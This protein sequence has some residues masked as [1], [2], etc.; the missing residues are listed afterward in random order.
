MN[1]HAAPVSPLSRGAA[2][3][4]GVAVGGQRHGAAE[5]A[6]TGLPA[7]GELFALLRPGFAPERVNTH[8]A[9]AVSVVDGPPI[10][11]VLPSAES[12]T[13]SRTS[14]LPVSSPPRELFALLGPG[15]ARA[16]E[17]PRGADAVVV[18]GPA[19][20]RGVAVG[21]QRHALAEFAPGRSH[22]RSSSI[23]AG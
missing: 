17:D 12:A 7:A 11:A 19:D 13:P 20:Q 2:D 3:Q 22:P 8:A 21:G 5:P 10:S 18:A 16:R 23:P 1:T 14:P 15:P 4:R 9:P 6:G